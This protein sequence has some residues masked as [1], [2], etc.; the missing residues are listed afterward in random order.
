MA[1]FKSATA[2]RLTR[3][4]EEERNASLSHAL[5][6]LEKR[7]VFDA[8]LA[9]ELADLAAT[10][11]TVLDDFVSGPSFGSTLVDAAHPASADDG[12]SLVADASVASAP[13]RAVYFVDGGIEGADEIIAGL[14][15]G[16]D[17]VVL[18]AT[19]DGVAQ[20]AEAMAS[21][22]GVDAIHVFSHGTEGALTL[23]STVLDAGSMT[24]V[25]ADALARIGEHLAADADI[26]IYGCDFAAGADGAH[27][28]DLLSVLTGAD[29]AASTDLT[30]ASARGGDWTL[31]YAIGSVET[32]ALAF[33][34]FDGTLDVAMISAA[35][36]PV[37]NGLHG[38]GASA[39][40]ANVATIAGQPIDIRATVVAADPTALVTFGVTGDDLRLE[41]Q[42]GTISVKWEL[43]LAGTNTPITADVN[44][45]ITD[46]DGPNIE[47]VA[48]ASASYTV[49]AATHLTTSTT[50]GVTTAQGTQNQNSEANSMIR[51]TWAGVSQMTVDYTGTSGNDIRI[52]NHDGDLDLAFS[53]PV[54]VGTPVLDLDTGTGGVDY[55]TTFTENGPAVAVIPTTV[56]V[57]NSTN[58]TSATLVLTNAKPGDTLAIGG[59]PGGITGTVDTSVPGQITVTLTGSAAA[60]AYETALHAVTFSNGSD[61]PDTTARNVTVQVQNGSYVSGTAISTIAVVPVNDA[62]NAVDDTV[63]TPVSTPITA[64]VATN[65][66]DPEG[67]TL[68][69]VL[70]TGP[71]HGTV[72]VATNGG[73]TYTPTAGWTGTDT[74][75]YTASDGNGG[76][77]TATVTVT[78]QGPPVAVDD[79][80]T[81][82]AGT[83][84]NASVA[85]NDTDPNGDTLTFTLGTGPTN[86]SV[87]LN[88]NGTYSYTPTAGWSGVDTFTYSVSD[89]N[90]G[91]DTATVTITVSNAAPVAGDDTF[92]TAASTA[93]TNTVAGNDSDPNGDTLTYALGAGPAHGTLTFSANGGFTY[94]PNAGW[95]GVDTFTY[96]ITDGNG[97]SDTATVTITTSNG[98]PVAGDDTASTPW[99]TVL[100]GS[101]TANDSD[102][103]G[104]PLTYVLGT[105]PTHGTVVMNTNGTFSYTPAV[106][107]TGADSFTYTVSDGNGG[108]ASATVS[109]TVGAR[110]NVVPVAVNDAVGTTVGTP[111]SGDAATND[112]DGDGDTLT[113][114]L[115]T[116]PAHGTVTLAPNGTFTYTPT[117]GWAGG[118]TFTYSVSDGFGGT[119]SATVSVTIDT[120]PTLEAIADQSNIDAQSVS[121]DLSGLLTD[122]DGPTATWSAT[123]LPPGLTIAPTTGLI[124]GTLDR[125]ASVS[126]PGGTGTYSVTVSVADGAGGTVSRTFAWT[127]TNP[128]PTAADDSASTTHSVA[129]SGN[130]AGNDTDPDG[131]VLTFTLNGGPAHG[132]AT[133]AAGGGFVYT[134]T[135]GFVGTDAFTYRVTD[136]QGASAVATVNV[137]VTDRAPVAIGT[138][139]GQAAVD[140][141]T[142][143]LPTT[144]YFSDPDGD[145]L[146]WTA[147]GLPTGLT[148]DPATGLIGGTIAAG[149]SGA[150]GQ[151]DYTVVVRATDPFGQFVTQSFTWRVTNVAPVAVADTFSASGLTAVSGSVATND[152]DADHDTLTYSLVGQSSRGRVTFAADGSFSYTATSLFSGDD[153]FTYSVSDGNGG[154]ANATVTV[155]VTAPTVLPSSLRCITTFGNLSHLRSLLM[156]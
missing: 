149:A 144:A 67:D 57:T 92:S 55:S 112:S 120:P 6:A 97:G 119:A 84:L 46:L 141:A 146:T 134:P 62:P 73:Y 36:A 102:P 38:L 49:D 45:Q 100:N 29:V 139:S 50:G 132:T 5:V 42:D 58:L 155:H 150:T 129:V 117:A 131:D 133:V 82:A 15:A 65:D 153:T 48:A 41:L 110:P 79:N 138:V 12:G 77:D 98:A 88:P 34:G 152:G 14:P 37:T 24:G 30:G 86:G 63:S 10:R 69:F 143:S 126:G 4:I 76:S 136:A 64:T 78:V 93:I 19:R 13:A 123:G 1:L 51:F 145:A 80:G 74:F 89:G 85:G 39:T 25:H 8:A 130:V 94:T 127:V 91:S 113:Y 142:V 115:A 43:F 116:G 35:G 128:A 108:T 72:T 71:S 44:F 54:T 95:S 20:I 107:Y 31:E 121:I 60:T 87:T 154:V 52:F 68:T 3:T 106:G 114:T 21:R 11:T 111:V 104:D 147:T 105:G 90:G 22:G 96:S 140:G 16:A 135:A 40:W 61:T 101:V 2:G 66:S 53:N 70:A 83:T 156:I 148:I 75:T 56:D 59:L 122:P 26:L 81:T 99:G 23:G 151:S 109:L 118:D 7:Y 47:Y 27:A 124:S 125:A 103:N 17:V 137:T 9:G 32:G 18:D 28:A 33:D